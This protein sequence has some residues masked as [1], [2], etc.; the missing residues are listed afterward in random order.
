MMRDAQGQNA[1]DALQQAWGFDISLDLPHRGI[2][3][4]TWQVGAVG[5]LARE[6]ASRLAET[7]AELGLLALLASNAAF[8]VPR[9]IP[10]RQG[11]P[12]AQIGDFTWTLCHHIA[13]ERF[14]DASASY[15]RLV[16]LLAVVHRTLHGIDARHAVV[17]RSLLDGAR[18]ALDAE[19]HAL[20]PAAH[21]ASAW[22]RERI[23]VLDAL[24]RQLIHGDFGIPNVLI[25][26]DEPAR[27]GVL[28]WEL[29]SHDSP[30][31]DL[32]QIAFG[33]IAFSR[34]TP[35]RAQVAALT[36]RYAE[37]GGQTFSEDQLLAALV[38]GRLA[39]ITW[40]RE[41]YVWGETTL[42]ESIRFLDERL[43]RAL[44]WLKRYD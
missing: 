1:A 36:R 23:A 8:D 27:F 38:A 32:A 30:I 4:L 33:M 20:S 3:R 25:D 41:R 7:R 43:K 15:E 10:T 37:H 28:D 16:A 18:D 42:G 44:R 14:A 24:P 2:S 17:Q 5:W 29:S 12:V 40:L 35:T 31:F 19:S 34:T 22:L 9:P 21:E 26:T 13:G 11:Q 6:A 39:Q